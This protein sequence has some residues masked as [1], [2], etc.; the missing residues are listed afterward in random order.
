MYILIDR[1]TGDILTRVN[2][3]DF[4]VLQNNLVRESEED[5]DFYINEPTLAFLQEN[6][7]SEEAGTALGP[8]VHSRGID[9]G[10]EP[11]TA[12]DEPVHFGTVVDD[13]GQPLGGIRLDLLDGGSLEDGGSSD[14]R[15]ILDWTYSRPDGTFALGVGSESPGTILRLSGRGDLVLE[16]RDISEIGD[17]GEIVIQTITGT[18]TN[19]I[20]DP[21]PKVS[22]QLLNWESSDG[23]EDAGDA[24]LGGTLSWGD[25]LEDGRFAIPVRLP[26]E[27]GPLEVSL[28]ILAQSGQSLLETVV[29]FDPADGFE[30]GTLTAQSPSE[31]WADGETLEPV[32]PD[33]EVFEH[34]LG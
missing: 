9:V 18:V 27:V 19:E 23:S 24:T 5:F 26:L 12:A 1:A 31:E 4:D 11:D 32:Q 15:K 2:P 6:G 28:E 22:V 34:P 25:T 33:H 29:E 8:R 13:E 3:K 14:G 17:K 20:G 30:I 7:L 16:L 10:W 21:L